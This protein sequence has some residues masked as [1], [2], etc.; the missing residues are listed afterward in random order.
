MASDHRNCITK[1]AP[2]FFFFNASGEQLCS[3]EKE[4]PWYFMHKIVTQDERKAGYHPVIK[5]WKK[6]D[7]FVG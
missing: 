6:S 5:Q 2:F 7:L 4:W 3:E 1:G